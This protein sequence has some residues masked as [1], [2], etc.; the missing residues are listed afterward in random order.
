[1]ITV[2]DLVQD[3]LVLDSSA[4]SSSSTLVIE[5]PETSGVLRNEKLSEILLATFPSQESVDMIVEMAGPM[6]S[7]FH[8]LVQQPY[9]DIQIG[10][11]ESQ[12]RLAVLTIRHTSKTHPL[13]IAQQMLLL[14]ISFRYIHPSF[15]HELTTF[16]EPPAVVMQRVA[17]T[18]IGLINTSD[19]ILSSIE[20]LE[21]LL[22]VG[23]YQA[24]GGNLRDCWLTTRRAMLTAQLMCLH[25]QK[26]PQVIT[27]QPGITRDL[28]YL[29]YRIVYYDRFFSLLLGLPQGS[30]DVSMGDG[31]HFEDDTAMGRFERRHC[32][33]A[34]RILKRNE[35]TPSS[36]NIVDTQAID[37]ELRKL[38]ESMPSKWW[39][40]PNLATIKNGSEMFW[41]T[42]RLTNQVF[43]YLLLSHLHLPFVLRS[44]WGLD[45]HR[46]QYNRAACI[47][48][49][50]ECLNR[51]MAFRTFSNISY[52]CH[53]MDFFAI[54]AS[55][56]LILAHLDG[57]RSGL[58]PD[59]T[60]VHQRTSDRAIMEEILDNMEQV[61]MLNKV[62]TISEK[63]AGVLR[64]LLAIEAD[65]NMGS[66]YRLE[67]G[68]AHPNDGCALR[69]SI[70]YFG[71]ITITQNYQIPKDNHDFSHTEFRNSVDT[72]VQAT[73]QASV[74][75]NFHALASKSPT[76]ESPSCGTGS[77]SLT[78][79]RQQS[80]K[81]TIH[82]RMEQHRTPGSSGVQVVDTG[83]TEPTEDFP[84][85]QST[86]AGLPASDV[87][88]AFQGVD[89]TFFD[90]LMKEPSIQP[91][92]NEDYWWLS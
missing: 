12:D 53:S 8:Q 70:P 77:V 82:S 76:F 7:F 45:Q 5:R 3:A 39:L 61:D 22:L 59:N 31:V 42:I 24:D 14:A 37:M 4:L 41:A 91:E 54:T 57:H 36:D 86:D 6:P 88:W 50:R 2:V 60:L 1:V 32:V 38:S 71:A 17:D 13:V 58:D 43:H 47:Q 80:I 10:D 21:C 16:S 78:S 81:S 23:S 65:A 79:Q 44:S 66:S 85:M 15:H 72:F 18:A 49:S 75:G 55:M 35:Q 20:G 27:V 51:Y 33:L 67:R 19:R 63:G 11:K 34:S 89:M 52:C 26:R 92:N 56:T 9:K 29:W 62:K 25:H 84:D 90:T 64:Q 74:R 40:I 30:T 73:H 69:L 83:L 48:A 28:Q 46:Y 87:D 68:C